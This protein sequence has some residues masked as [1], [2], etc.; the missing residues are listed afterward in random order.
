MVTMMTAHTNEI[1][2]PED[3]IAEILEQIDLK[4]LKKNSIGL[5]FC[6]YEFIES[7]I[8]RQ[9][10]EKLPFEIVGMTT[11]AGAVEGDAGM[12]SLHLAVL[13]SDEI[14]FQPAH[15]PPLSADTFDSTIKQTCQEALAKLDGPPQ[16]VI[17]FFPFSSSLSGTDMLQVIDETCGGAPVWGGVSSDVS[18]NYANSRV[19]CND[20]SDKNMLTLVLLRGDVQVDFVVTSIPDRNIYERQAIITE[21]EHCTVKKVNDMT[22]YDFLKSTNIIAENENLASTPIVVYRKDEEGAYAT[23]IYNMYDDGSALCGSPMPEGDAFSIAEIDAVGI[24]ESA[25][26]SLEKTLEK[27]PSLVLML[28]CITRYFMLAPS[29]EDEMRLVSETIGQRFPF[30]H[31]YAGGEICPISKKDGALRNKFHGFTFSACLLK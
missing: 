15:T 16:L 24:M 29:Q 4:A 22:F 7:G 19:I 31:A 18:A 14:K 23:A 30:V 26:I 21:S 27:N 1:D 20:A 11:L 17:A 5:V 25:Q 3:A 28:P 12:Y 13:T 9:L 2:E 10:R 8:V 6:Y